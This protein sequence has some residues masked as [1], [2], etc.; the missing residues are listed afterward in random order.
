MENLYHI[1]SPEAQGPTREKC[2]ICEGGRNVKARGRGGQHPGRGGQR[3]LDMTGWPYSWTQSSRGS[4]MGLREMS[5]SSQRSY[6]QCM[7]CGGLQLVCENLSP[8]AHTQHTY[9]H[10]THVH[11]FT[12]THA[13]KRTCYLFFLMVFEAKGTF[14]QNQFHPC[15]SGPRAD[16]VIW[17]EHKAAV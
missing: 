5:S 15:D 7:A 13:C 3:L 16:S 9:T 4:S 1:L 12:G 14:L 11:T 8:E 2:C 10:I 17:L 6:W